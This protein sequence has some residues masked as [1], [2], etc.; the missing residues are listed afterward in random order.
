LSTPEGEIT[1]LLHDIGSGR[2]AAE[3]RL[4]AIAYDRLHRIAA[5][6][7]RKGG[8][9]VTIN[10]T[11]LV[12]EAY[13]KLRPATL[14]KI[15]SSGH[16]YRIVSRAMRQ[17]VVDLIR[18][19]ASRQSAGIRPVTLDAGIPQEGMGFDELL[20]I[21]T[22]LTALEAVDSEL[23]QLVEWRFYGGLEIDEIAKLLGVTE[24]TVRRR[25]QVAKAL[26]GDSLGAQPAASS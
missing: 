15:G 26:L 1:Q 20:S 14:A 21:D 18:K 19:R 10:P 12:S 16:F 22:A 5:S 8:R 2:P 3:A 13:V 17:V 11:A 25:W 9:M 24:R 23:A 6:H 7:V 4:Y